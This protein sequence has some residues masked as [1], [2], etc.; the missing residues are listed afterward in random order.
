[1]YLSDPQHR[2][3]VIGGS[4]ALAIVIAIILVSCE[5]PF[6]FR[7]SCTCCESHARKV[8]VYLTPPRCTASLFRTGLCSGFS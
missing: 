7:L 3:L 1:M 4:C 5:Q 6:E 8:N 2:D